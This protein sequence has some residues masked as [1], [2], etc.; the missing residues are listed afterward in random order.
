MGAGRALPWGTAHL[1]WGRGTRVL[2]LLATTI[3]VGVGNRGGGGAVEVRETEP[4]GRRSGRKTGSPRNYRT[5]GRVT[6]T[7]YRSLNSDIKEV[8]RLIMFGKTSFSAVR[9]LFLFF[10]S[11]AARIAYLGIIYWLGL[12]WIR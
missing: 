6:R 5:P 4:P 12:D 10:P 3:C 7:F 8:T 9:P 11:G 2:L 1:A